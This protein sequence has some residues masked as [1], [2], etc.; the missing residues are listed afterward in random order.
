[1]TVEKLE[2]LCHEYICLL[3]NLEEMP[4]GLYH[5]DKM[6]SDCHDRLCKLAGKTKEETK[7]FTDHLDLTDDE[8][9]WKLYCKLKG[10]K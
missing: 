9:A 3:R 4:K 8:C 10:W 1:M 2:L 7:K 5:L 6:R